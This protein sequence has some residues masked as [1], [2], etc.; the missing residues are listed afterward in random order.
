MEQKTPKR[1]VEKRES[2]EC[3]RRKDRERE[4]ERERESK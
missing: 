2:M 1:G 4:R 3:Q